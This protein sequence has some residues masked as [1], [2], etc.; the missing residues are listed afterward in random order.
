[1]WSLSPP[2]GDCRW[3]YRSDY[4]IYIIFHDINYH[5]WPLPRSSARRGGSEFIENENKIINSRPICVCPQSRTVN[6]AGKSFNQPTLDLIPSDRY[7]DGM[8][9]RLSR[10]HSLAAAREMIEAKLKGSRWSGPERLIIINCRWNCVCL[11]VRARRGVTSTCSG[12]HHYRPIEALRPLVISNH[13]LMLR[14]Q[15]A[16]TA[17][18]YL[19]SSGSW[20]LSSFGILAGNEC[21]FDWDVLQVRKQTP[22]GCE[23]RRGKIIYFPAVETCSICIKP[24]GVICSRWSASRSLLAGCS[25]S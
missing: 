10:P 20:K 25:L 8:L 6:M 14:S 17:Q 18:L 22:E 24:S 2:A 11:G 9:N 19:S 1:M 15:R 13:V 7:A 16:S 23:E 21:W 4:G 3:C 12:R 5:R